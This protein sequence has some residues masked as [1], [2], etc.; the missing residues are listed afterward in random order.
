[1]RA[2]GRE[3]D[4]D[5][6]LYF[7]G[8]AT[9][10][11]LGWRDTTIDADIRIVPESDAIYRALPILKESLELNIELACPS[12]FIPELPG[13]EERSPFIE[14]EGLVSFHH[15]DPYA[16]ALAKVERGHDQDRRDVAQMRERRLVEPARALELFASIEPALY[17][18]PA[19]DPPSFRRAVEAAFA[20]QNEP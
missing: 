18:Y 15:Y 4:R 2:V 13:W 11:L 10:V 7:T 5:C 16:Q 1:M 17:R 6:R 19:I 3:A 12:D 14:R 20:P 9:A 8:G